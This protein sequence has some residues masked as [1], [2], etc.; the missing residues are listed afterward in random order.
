MKKP[1]SHFLQ[2][3]LSI[4]DGRQ[5]IEYATGT[6]LLKQICRHMPYQV[7]LKKKE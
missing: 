5:K 2:V 4:A 6:G 3:Q 1:V 7:N